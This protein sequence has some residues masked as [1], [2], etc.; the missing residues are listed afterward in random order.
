MPCPLHFIYV[1]SLALQEEGVANPWTMSFFGGKVHLF[2]VY[3][4]LG[5]L[6]MFKSTCQACD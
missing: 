1:A 6:C 5:T 2:W 3:R 4:T